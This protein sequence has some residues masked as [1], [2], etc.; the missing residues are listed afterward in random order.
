M[1]RLSIAFR[2]WHDLAPAIRSQEALDQQTD[3][4][5]K[6]GGGRG[7]TRRVT[8]D[9]EQRTVQSNRSNIPLIRGESIRVCR[10]DLFVSQA[11]IETRRLERCLG[12]L[13]GLGWREMLV[14]YLI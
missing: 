4:M 1:L 5:V 6:G 2:T 12:R 9:G 11:A 8:T 3:G 14:A 13:A 7:T 10:F